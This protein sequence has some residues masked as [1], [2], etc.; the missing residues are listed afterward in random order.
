[1]IDIQ[2]YI[3]NFKNDFGSLQHHAPWQIVK[4]IQVHIEE[5]IRT[6][7]SAFLVSNNVA[8]HQSAKLEEGCIIKGPAIIS[9]GCFI[10][11][12]AYIRGGVCLGENVVVG[13][14]TEIKSSLILSNTALAHFNFVGD[15][16]IGSGVNMEAGSVIANHFN[17]RNDKTIFILLNGV[18]T[19]IDSNKFGALVGDNSRIG[20]NSVLSPGTLLT[21]GSVVRRLELVEQA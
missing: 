21:P 6:L 11:A 19:A 9:A 5:K 14:G 20:A 2:Q 12:H 3:G 15:S 8:I 4:N 1:M 7:P 18:R 13:P 17:E 16:L 10:A